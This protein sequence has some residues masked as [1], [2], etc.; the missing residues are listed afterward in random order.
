MKNWKY[1]LI[2]VVLLLLLFGMNFVQVHAADEET[3][4]RQAEQAGKL[5]QALTYY[6]EALKV[7]INNQKLREKIIKLVRKIQPPPALPDEARRFTVR[8]Q[9]AIKEAKNISDYKEAILEFNK[10]LRIAPWWADA[11]FNLAVAQEKAEQFAKAIRNLKLYLLAAPHAPDYQKVE[12]QIYA[13]EYRM[14]KLVKKKKRQQEK[15]SPPRTQELVGYWNVKKWRRG[16]KKHDTIYIGANGNKILFSKF[17]GLSVFTS[18]RS[19]VE[20]RLHGFELEGIVEHYNVK[21]RGNWRKCPDIFSKS[22]PVTSFLIKGMV[23]KDKNTITLSF[24][25][26]YLDYD[27]DCNRIYYENDNVVFTRKD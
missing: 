13:L 2:N 11:Y 12:D 23:S 17:P 20:L 1:I 3:L 15:I 24:S 6:V 4:G 7:D 22:A 5:R 25:V 26:P 19:R 18:G 14:E 21:F 16:A 27:R 8:G 9:T 10:A